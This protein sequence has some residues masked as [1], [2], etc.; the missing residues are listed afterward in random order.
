MIIYNIVTIIFIVLYMQ[1]IQLREQ[2]AASG[3]YWTV[4]LILFVILIASLG[5][6]A[7]RHWELNSAIE[8]NLELTTTV[9]TLREHKGACGTEQLDELKECRIKLQELIEIKGKCLVFEENLRGNSSLALVKQT[10]FLMK[11]MEEFKD[12][13][14][15][16][17]E[18]KDKCDQ[19]LQ[20]VQNQL[21]MIMS[22]ATALIL[23]KE[24]WKNK[25]KK[26]QDLS[27]NQENS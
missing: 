22:N 20:H 16:D 14:A 10:D 6:I 2:V 25:Y 23:E 13:S 7:N 26:C 4:S 5:V 11:E 24:E 21:S 8:R 9:Q 12:R 17:A 18:R 3:T 27:T 1:F 15:K 19:H